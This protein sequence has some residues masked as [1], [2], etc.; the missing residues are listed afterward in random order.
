MCAPDLRIGWHRVIFIYFFHGN[1]LFDIRHGMVSGWWQRLV[2]AC[3][4]A[5]SRRQIGHSSA[6]RDEFFAVWKCVKWIEMMQIDDV[7]LAATGL[8]PTHRHVTRLGIYLYVMK[9]PPF[10]PVSARFHTEKDCS[11]MQLV[12]LGYPASLPVASTGY[13]ATHVYIVQVSQ[14][15]HSF[16]FVE[17]KVSIPICKLM[18]SLSD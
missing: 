4:R 11:W 2:L 6:L 14:F 18:W 8:S 10:G 5:E 15:S 17:L 7:K 9:S 12:S 16:C 13:T 3:G 1:I